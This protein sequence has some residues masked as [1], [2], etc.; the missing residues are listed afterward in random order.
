MNYTYQEHGGGI[1]EALGLAEDFAD[2]EGICVVLGDNLIE[3]NIIQAAESFQKQGNG[4]K[5]ILKQVP[6]AQRFGFAEFRGDRLVK[7]EESLRG[8][9]IRL[10]RG[11]YLLLRWQRI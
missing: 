4:A 8:S 2:G 10:C 7:I 5:V 3:Y 11:R 9:Q 6:D 1:A